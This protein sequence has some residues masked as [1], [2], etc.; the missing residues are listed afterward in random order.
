MTHWV[1]YP[2]C[3]FLQSKW[4]LGKNVFSDSLIAVWGVSDIMWSAV[5][6]GGGGYMF[7]LVSSVIGSIEP[8]YKL[9]LMAKML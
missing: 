1:F 5:F 9:A 6:F 3:G 4:G 2:W 7:V 8:A